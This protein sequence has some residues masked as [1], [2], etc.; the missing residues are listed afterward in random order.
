MAQ[1]SPPTNV[2]LT[3][4]I[5]PD[6]SLAPTAADIGIAGAAG[7]GI[8]VVCVIN[9]DQSQPMGVAIQAIYANA[10]IPL[11]YARYVINWNAVKAAMTGG[12]KTVANTF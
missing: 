11:P 6:G 2:G 7:L 3:L 9:L 1:V 5:G 10:G 8:G 4:K 12:A